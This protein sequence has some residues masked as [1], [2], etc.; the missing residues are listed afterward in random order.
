MLSEG[1]QTQKATLY[2]VSFVWNIQ[3]RQIY[4]SRKWFSC[5]QGA[6][7]KGEWKMNTNGY[8]V[9]F[10]GD[11]CVLELDGGYGW[12]FVSILKTTD[13]QTL[14]EWMLS[15]DLPLFLKSKW[16]QIF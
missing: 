9:S 6:G 4:R 7:G 2:M 10:E 16:K 14:K 13:L 12:N 1:S 5:F 8:G 15:W 11:E 3:N